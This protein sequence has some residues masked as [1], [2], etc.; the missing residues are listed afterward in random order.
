MELFTIGLF[1]G[2]SMCSVAT[3]FGVVSCCKKD[4]EEAEG[5]KVSWRAF[6]KELKRF[7]LMVKAE[8]QAN[9]EQRRQRRRNEKRRK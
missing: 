1:V 4:M 6:F 9:R 8:E 5:K 7:Y 2:A 3:L